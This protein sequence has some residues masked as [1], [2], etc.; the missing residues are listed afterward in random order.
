M[1]EKDIARM[2][3][4]TDSKSSSTG[5]ESETQVTSANSIPDHGT[6]EQSVPLT[7]GTIPLTLDAI[8][9]YSEDSE[10]TRA[11][12]LLA[13]PQ[14]HEESEIQKMLADSEYP[15]VEA[16]L[17]TDEHKRRFD[18]LLQAENVALLS[19]FYEDIATG[20]ICFYDRNDYGEIT[21]H[22]IGLMLTPE[23]ATK[24]KDDLGKPIPPH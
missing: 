15:E 2:I 19:G 10:S 3:E 5:Y 16:P 9:E 8:E 24:I 17:L 4:G 12:V 23:M 7:L 6:D 1:T 18:I 20:L 21:I 14:F 22:P 11:P 13:I